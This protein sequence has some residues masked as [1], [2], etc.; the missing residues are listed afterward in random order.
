MAQIPTL[1]LNDGNEIPLVS[2]YDF[3]ILVLLLTA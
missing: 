1:K 3:S 2:Y